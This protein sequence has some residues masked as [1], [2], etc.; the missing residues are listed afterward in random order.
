MANDET[1]SAKVSLET[2]DDLGQLIKESGLTSKEFLEQLIITHKMVQLQGS[3]TQRS[4]D[5][6]QVNYH[7]DK[8]KAAF[9][10]LV[11]KG[12]DLA[13]MYAEKLEL[14]SISHKS[15]VDQQQQAILQSQ[16]EKENAIREKAALGQAIEDVTAR[17]LEFAEVNASQRITMQM[18][19]EKLTSLESRIAAVG[20]LEQEI[21]SLR[22]DHEQSQRNMESLDRDL[23]NTKHQAEAAKAAHDTRE[24]E[25]TKATEQQTKVHQLELDKAVLQAEKSVQESYLAK[26]EALNEQIKAMSEMNQALLDKVHKVELAAKP[27]AAPGT[28]RG[29]TKH[30]AQSEQQEGEKVIEQTNK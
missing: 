2:K 22:H 16:A 14:E 11:E 30:A 19:M 28:G 20:E 18:Q 25:L 26:M 5:I 13:G 29:K 7:L 1:W 4:E 15:I 8:V 21:S 6:Q 3:E 9:V 24:R 17:N 10:V 23:I 27:V 12:S